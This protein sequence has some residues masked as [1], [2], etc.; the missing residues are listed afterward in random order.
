MSRSRL[1]ALCLVVLGLCLILAN[2][3]RLL[4]VRAYQARGAP[5]DGEVKRFSWL[6]GPPVIFK[7]Q[8]CRYC[9]VEDHDNCVLDFLLPDSPVREEVLKRLPCSCGPCAALRPR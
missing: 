7:R 8:P 2:G 9:A 3:R 6:P 5:F 1:I 4:Y